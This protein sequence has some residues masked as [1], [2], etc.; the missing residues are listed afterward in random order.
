M[1]DRFSR[2]LVEYNKE[3]LADMNSPFNIKCRRTRAI[4]SSVIKLKFFEIYSMVSIF[5]KRRVLLGSYVHKWDYEGAYNP[6]NGRVAIYTCIY[7]KYDSPKEPIYISDKCDYY[8]FT[9][10]PVSED[11][12]WKRKD[13]DFDRFEDL[14][15]FSKNRFI[16]MNPHKIFSDYEYSIYIDGTIRL[17]AD[18][19]PIIESMGESFLSVCEHPL[20]GCIYKE[21][22]AFKYSKRLR[23]YYKPVKRQTTFYKQQGFP[24]NNGMFENTILIRKHNHKNCITLMDAWWQEYQK[25]PT[26]DQISLPY[27]TWKLGIK[28]SNIYIFDSDLGNNPRFK[29]YSHI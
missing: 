3:V 15:N 27:V 5:L 24:E 14:D 8:V 23:Q 2:A 12:I 18:P 22:L 21:C 29:R 11:S 1:E 6:I 17:I 25:Y 10:Q 13:F 20:R 26:R 19:L 4:A 16:K 7:G 9:D 28:R